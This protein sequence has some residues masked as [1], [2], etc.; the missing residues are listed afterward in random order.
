MSTRLRILIVDE[1]EESR[2]FI[3][4]A[5]KE[6][7]HN[8]DTASCPGDAIE[9]LSKETYDLVVFDI[10]SESMPGLALLEKAKEYNEFI[11]GIV[12]TGAV[13]IYSVLD[14]YRVGV[15]DFLYKPLRN[16][17]RLLKAVEGVEQKRAHWLEILHSLEYHWP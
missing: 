6:T 5:L 12:V 15:F 2:S 16:K 10:W 1:E 11:E 14:C 4:E 8:S 7:E 3:A 17:K 13:S 9:M